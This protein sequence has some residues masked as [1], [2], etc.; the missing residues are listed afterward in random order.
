MFLLPAIAGV[1]GALVMGSTK[2]RTSY[3]KMRALG[4]RSGMTYEIEDFTSAGFVVVRA[5]DGSEG[6][7]SRRMPQD[8]RGAGFD[9]SRGK[10]N[11]ATLKLMHTDFIA[12]GSRLSPAPPRATGTPP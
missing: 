12:A 7:L 5:P 6:V 4:S 8:P 10:G 1:V 3:E 9:W 11:P 2:P